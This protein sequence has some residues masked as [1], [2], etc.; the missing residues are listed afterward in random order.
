MIQSTDAN[1]EVSAST[2]IAGPA[3][4]RSRAVIPGSPFASWMR[5]CR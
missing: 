3:S 5:D 4:R 2:M 1:E